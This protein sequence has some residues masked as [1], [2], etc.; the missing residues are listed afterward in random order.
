MGGYTD[1]P[2]NCSN[3]L[4]DYYCES[5][6]RLCELSNILAGYHFQSGIKNRL[7]NVLYFTTL[8]DRTDK[9]EDEAFYFSLLCCAAPNKDVRC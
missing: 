9:R 5:R 8:N 6:E 2:F 4:F 1:K 3:Y 7:K